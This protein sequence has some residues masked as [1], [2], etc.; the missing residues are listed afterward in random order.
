MLDLPLQPLLGLGLRGVAA[1]AAGDLIIQL[2]LAF[3][4]AA[5]AGLVH[6]FGAGARLHRTSLETEARRLNLVA[7][8][9]SGGWDLGPVV[10]TE[11]FREIGGQKAEVG[12]LRNSRFRLQPALVEIPADR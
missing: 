9:C 5:F 2:G 10:T 11:H 7:P 6:E 3:G 8:Q 4:A 12:A 1:L